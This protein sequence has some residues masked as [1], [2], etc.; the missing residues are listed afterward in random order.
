MGVSVLA[1]VGIILV[2]EV[3]SN[4]EDLDHTFNALYNKKL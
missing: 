2:N 3:L 1:M 4:A